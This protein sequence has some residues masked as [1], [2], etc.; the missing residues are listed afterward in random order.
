[1]VLKPASKKTAVPMKRPVTPAMIALPPSPTPAEANVATAKATDH[2]DA[3]SDIHGT[4]NSVLQSDLKYDLSPPVVEVS[5]LNRDK[6]QTTSNGTPTHASV[7]PVDSRLSTPTNEETE[8]VVVSHSLETPGL[9]TPE[10]QLSAT[11]E[12]VPCTPQSNLLPNPVTLN[13]TVLGA[14]TP[15]SALLS[16]IERGFLYSPTTPLSPADSYLPGPNG[17]IT[18]SH[19]THAPRIEGPM[20]PFNYALHATPKGSVFSNATVS[21]QEMKLVCGS[22]GVVDVNEHDKLYGMTAGLPRSDDVNRMR[23]VFV[24]PTQSE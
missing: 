19:E 5:A 9:D 11:I 2:V 14:K 20:Q 13:A 24:E 15:I 23:N 6:D 17:T 16:S 8:A 1:V 7:S 12:H 10:I 3:E 18:Y 21:Q 4:S 22:I